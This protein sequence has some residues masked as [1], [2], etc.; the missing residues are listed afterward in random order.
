MLALMTR[1]KIF[2]CFGQGGKFCGRRCL[3]VI[4]YILHRNQVS[5]TSPGVTGNRVMRLT[6]LKLILRIP[7]ICSM[8]GDHNFGR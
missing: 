5:L 2:K 8:G 3:A 6:L 4:V 1:R 7:G